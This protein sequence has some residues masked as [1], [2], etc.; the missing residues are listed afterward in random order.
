MSRAASTRRQKTAAATTVN[1]GK[2][3]SLRPAQSVV[4]GGT[5]GIGRAV[6]QLLASQGHAVSVLS[7]RPPE[8]RIAGTRHWAA[9]LLDASALSE[10]V[11]RIVDQAPIR[12]LVFA[13]RY[14]GD[15]GWRGELEAGL[16]ATRDV[17]EVCDA[18]AAWHAPASIVVV[19]SL[20]GQFVDPGC[21]L[22][23]Q[24]AKA[25]VLELARY[26]ALR[27][28]PRGVRVNAVVPCAIIKEESRDYYRQQPSLTALYEKITPLRRMGTAEEIAQ[29]IG[30][31]CSPASS[32]VT[33][34]AIVADGGVS[35]ITQ[36]SLAKQLL[37]ATPERTTAR[38]ERR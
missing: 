16:R 30:F 7:R 26:Y 2:M 13:Q 21:S 9:D 27:L 19:G 29:V 11:K 36:E 28:G 22:G 38:A 23:Y 24:V 34:Q 8:Q 1:S 6:A 32:F 12:H 37:P 10:I 4:I 5:R 33:G 18:A 31:L 14:R 35:L 20:V 17:I 25:G 3:E 15:D